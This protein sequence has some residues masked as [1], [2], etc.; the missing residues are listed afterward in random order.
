M[1]VRE[2]D[3]SLTM[4]RLGR[5]AV[6]EG[7]S[8]EEGSFRA[9]YERTARPLWTYLYRASGNLAAADDVMQESYF[10]LLRIRNL[11]EDELG[12]RKY[13]FRIAS[14]LLRDGWRRGKREI[15]SPL[16]LEQE[17]MLEEDLDT[18]S[19]LRNAFDQLSPRERQIL[20]LA[21][22]EDY[23]HREIAALTGL[24]HGSIRIL[25]FRARH[26]LAGIL[27]GRART[28]KKGSA[29]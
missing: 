1:M 23:D 24:R 13:L 8:M 25:L 3:I 26:K 22:V 6:A 29:P 7:F 28:A 18:V 19:D 17:P 5:K 20:W 2:L 27:R 21:Y 9:F 11:P 16:N 14:N 15:T 12:R 10:H 4:L